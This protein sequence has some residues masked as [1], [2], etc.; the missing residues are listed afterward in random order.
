MTSW[1][2][3]IMANKYVSGQIDTEIEIYIFQSFNEVV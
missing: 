2:R 1:P 3:E